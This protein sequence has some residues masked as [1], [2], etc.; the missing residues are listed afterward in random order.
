[1]LNNC[2][3]IV[4]DIEFCTTLF[5]T[6][7]NPVTLVSNQRYLQVSVLI[8]HHAQDLVLTLRDG[9]L[10][11]IPV[12][13][14]NAMPLHFTVLFP[15]GDRGWNKDERHTTGGKTVTAKEFAVFHLAERD[16]RDQDCKLLTFEQ[17]L[18]RLVLA[19]EEE[20][21]LSTVDYIHRGGR[22]FQEKVCLDWIT[23]EDSR[24]DWS[25][26]NQKKLR[27]DS[28][29]N[30]RQVVDAQG[31]RRV[32]GEPRGD[33]LYPE[34]RQLNYRV[35]A[36]ILPSS[37]TGSPRW[38][39]GKYQ[40]SMRICQEYGPPTFFITFTGN[41]KWKEITSNLAPGMK[42][43]DRP[44]LVARVFKQKYD[45]LMDC[46]IKC[47]LLGTVVAHMAVVEW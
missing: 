9:G 7:V 27:A 33:M 17:I 21:H 15:N 6:P 44:D 14:S 46:L 12:L 2:I 37:K 39:Y 38:Y 10:Q 23:V 11:T 40:D 24:L 42:T 26:Q 1:M 32:A 36:K 34:D 43:E 30:V 18:E 22:L 3:I 8:D 25:A 35:G 20:G 47:N 4:F 45:A 28:Y 5:V 13:N 31:R 41:P 29:R 16:P 19:P